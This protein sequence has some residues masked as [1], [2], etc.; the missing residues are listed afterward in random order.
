[1]DEAIVHARQKICQ[2]FGNTLETKATDEYCLAFASPDGRAPAIRPVVVE[3][4]PVPRRDVSM[5]SMVERLRAELPREALSTAHAALEEFAG[6]S[7]LRSAARQMS[8]TAITREVCV[9]DLRE[10][11]E[12]AAQPILQQLRR[13]AASRF[14]FIRERSRFMGEELSGL[15]HCWLNQSVRTWADPLLLAELASDPLVTRLDIPRKLILEMHVSM[16]TIGAV[17]YRECTGLTGKGV[18][19]AVIDS[20]VRADHPALLGRVQPKKSYVLPHWGNPHAHGTAVAGIIAADG[21][22][23]G[24]APGA[25]IYNY[26]V[27]SGLGEAADDIDGACAIQKALEHGARI[28]NCSWGTCAPTDGTSREARA[29][30]H[31]WECGMTVVKS[32]GNAGKKSG[33]IT[34]PGDAEGVIVVGATS[35]N[36]KGVQEYS[37]QGPTQNGRTRP[38]L[39][40]PGG[41]KGWPITT[42]STDGEFNNPEY[43]TSYAAAHVSGVLA[44]L[45]ER[46]PDLTPK[47]QMAK[48]LEMC[49]PMVGG[50]NTTGKGLLV[51]PA[52]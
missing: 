46:E 35:R 13:D 27:H 40:A 18:V 3:M 38:H 43:G 22:Y 44:L 26:V 30:D 10:R 5:Q 15:Q 42:A 32:A 23:K 31:A 19:V 6:N 1:M 37:S 12:A 24:V 41:N 7:F 14:A 50:E 52:C 39:V 33:T 48:L 8:P 49:R 36:G 28:A 34:S 21:E 20:E 11:S 25:I 47:E 9:A 2:A 45:L 4:Q 29:C 16:K 17:K 51:L